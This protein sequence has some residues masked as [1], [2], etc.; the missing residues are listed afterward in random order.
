ML[1]GIN[2][3]RFFRGI[4]SF[5]E[6]FFDNT[7][8]EIVAMFDLLWS[9]KNTDSE[10]KPNQSNPI[11]TDVR[12]VNNANHQRG[13]TLLL[14]VSSSEYF[15]TSDNFAGLK[16][17]VHDPAAYPELQSKALAIGNAHFFNARCRFHNVIL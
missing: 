4:K 5:Q 9:H 17:L 3:V 12:R 14:N 13:L 1:I 10:N 11:K 6:E 2:P 16:L 7:N 15:I 8:H